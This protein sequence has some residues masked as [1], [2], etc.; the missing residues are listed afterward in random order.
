MSVLR[1][2]AWVRPDKAQVFGE[3]PRVTHDSERETD[4]IVWLL[5]QLQDWQAAPWR[6]RSQLAPRDQEAQVSTNMKVVWA[7][8][9]VNTKG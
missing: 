2:Q 9:S 6:A 1:G 4:L 3:G 5:V 8:I 7:D